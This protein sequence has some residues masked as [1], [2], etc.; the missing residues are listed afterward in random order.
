MTTLP[1][2]SGRPANSDSINVFEL[3]SIPNIDAGTARTRE[4]RSVFKTNAEDW[5]FFDEVDGELY[6]NFLAVNEAYIRIQDAVASKL[7]A[8]D[9]FVEAKIKRF[10][11]KNVI[12][13]LKRDE[14]VYN[15]VLVQDFFKDIIN[16]LG[17]YS[18]MLVKMLSKDMEKLI[19]KNIEVY[20]SLSQEWR[21]RLNLG[22]YVSRFNVNEVLG[23]RKIK[24]VGAIVNKY[25]SKYITINGTVNHGSYV[26]VYQ[27]EDVEASTEPQFEVSKANETSNKSENQ[28]W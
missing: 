5:D 13:I 17:W 23:H 14:A 18:D 6:D 25:A 28:V 22:S 8:Y 15:L 26:G 3:F 1:Q 9:G 12:E 4:T 11:E 10:L 20:D 24:S 7:L 16:R 2:S 19:I 27:R 21:V